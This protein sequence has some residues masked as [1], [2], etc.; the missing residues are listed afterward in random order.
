MATGGAATAISAPVI[1]DG[2]RFLEDH[3]LI[4][5]SG[6]VTQLLA[7]S[8][9]APDIARIT[10]TS[11]ILAPGFID[12]QVNGGG[13]LMF[14]NNPYRAALGTMFAAHR[15][16]GT[17]AMMPTLISDTPAQ[18]ELA[19]A[20]VREAIAGDDPGILGIHLEGPF[21]AS[22]RRGAHRARR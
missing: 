7:T 19:V 10:L 20:A 21:F 12:L 1:F 17:T 15:R 13:D 2:T 6:L 8:D 4:T 11:G 5:Q 16:T 3:C 22:A 14:N 18:Q 9:C